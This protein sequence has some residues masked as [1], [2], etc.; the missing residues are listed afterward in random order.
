[1]SEVLGKIDVNDYGVQSMTVSGSSTEDLSVE[2]GSQDA[3][4][5][6]QETK[7][8]QL[9]AALDAKIALDLTNATSD[10]NATAGDI[11]KN[12]TAYVNGNKVTGTLESVDLADYFNS[13]FTSS[14]NNIVKIIKRI[15]ANIS[16][17][18]NNINLSNAFANCINLVEVPLFDTTNVV[19]MLN[20]FNNCYSLRTIPLFIT[21][22]VTSMQSMFY[23]CSGLT[24]I[25]LFN[26]GNVANMQEM[27][28]NCGN[29]TTIPLL[30]T[31]NVTN[32]TNMFNMCSLLSN[33][34]LNNILAMC[35]NSAITSNKTLKKIGLSSAQATT[36]QSL[37][38]WDAFVA[39][40]WTTGY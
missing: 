34:S 21:S 37:S 31:S 11:A 13:Y 3:A 14:N 9:E 25:P 30:N 26:T 20:M 33:D 4:L 15:P 29:L 12:K 5:S 32:M 7:I 17:S 40:G 39:A 8:D 23:N 36:C 24:S 28:S 27:V 16:V 2:L 22:N 10:A 35:I 38:N 18:G 19:N 1:M 6:L